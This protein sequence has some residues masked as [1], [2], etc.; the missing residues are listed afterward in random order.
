MFIQCIHVRS[1]HDSRPGSVKEVLELQ[2][3]L[4][5]YLLIKNDN[6]CKLMP[7][8]LAKS[9]SKFLGVRGLPQ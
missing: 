9:R 3:T 1:G 8:K 5:L 7:E 4:L 2:I 6:I